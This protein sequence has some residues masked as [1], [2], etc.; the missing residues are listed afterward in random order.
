MTRT[1]ISHHIVY[2][3]QC[4]NHLEL[5]L[6]PARHI[7][8]VAWGLRDKGVLR[9]SGWLAV[10]SITFP[11]GFPAAMR[12]LQ[13]YCSAFARMPLQVDDLLSS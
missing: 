13:V 10:A 7:A 9:E 4:L 3:F 2:I 12:Q 5:K 6:Q 1:C 11:Q 8:C